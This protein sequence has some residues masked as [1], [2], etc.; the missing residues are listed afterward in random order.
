MKQIRKPESH[1]ITE[2]KNLTERKFGLKKTATEL[3]FTPQFIWDVVNGKRGMTENLA[4]AM[5]YRRV[6]EYERAA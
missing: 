5:G 2:L 6:V 4:N 3:G 1:L